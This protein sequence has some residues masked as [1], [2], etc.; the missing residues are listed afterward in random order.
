M[1]NEASVKHDMWRHPLY[2]IWNAMMQR[3]HNPKNKQYPDY[4]ARGIL[5]C[6]RWHSVENFIADLVGAPFEGAMLEREKNDEGYSPENCKWATRTE[7]NRNKR[8]N[9]LFEY[10]GRSQLIIDWAREIG[11][12]HRTLVSRVYN[13]GWSMDKAINTPVK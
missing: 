2:A 10:N 7:Q 4:G 11:M 9:R 6:E 12:N 13:Y 5:V 8:N 1:R 3:C